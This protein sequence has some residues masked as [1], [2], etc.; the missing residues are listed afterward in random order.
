MGKLKFKRGDLVV[1]DVFP[2]LRGVVIQTKHLE[3][4]LDEGEFRTMLHY[5]VWWNDNSYTYEPAR[6]I[7]LV[8]SK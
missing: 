4:E 5:H 1:H 7:R 8:E 3:I 2:E 6:D